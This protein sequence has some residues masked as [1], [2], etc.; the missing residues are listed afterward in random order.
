M[1]DNLTAKIERAIAMLSS[2]VWFIFAFLYVTSG[3]IFISG[4]VENDLHITR[5]EIGAVI[6]MLWARVEMMN[7]ERKKL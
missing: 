1:L 5:N 7:V 6:L 3:I 4:V 2:L